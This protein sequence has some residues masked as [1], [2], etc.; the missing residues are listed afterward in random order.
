M[1]ENGQV[2]K[3]REKNRKTSRFKSLLPRRKNERRRVE[4]LGGLA[5]S[6][7]SLLV[8][9]VFLASS[10]D[11][12]LIRSNQY[13]SV[14]AAVLV[15]LTNGDRTQNSLHTLTMNPT[16]VAAAQA[17]ANDMATKGY[18]A[19]VGPDGKDSWYWFKEIGYGFSYAGE[20]LAVDFSDSGDVE[21]AWMNS[22]L[23]RQNLLDPHFTE[24]GI[25]TAQGK[26]QGHA[27]T[28]VVQMFGTSAEAA[29]IKEPVR[30]ITSPQNATEPAIATTQ[31]TPVNVLGETSG[32]TTSKPLPDMRGSEAASIDAHYAPLWAHIATA[33]RSMLL[34][35][36]WI[37]AF[38]V[39]LALGIATGFELHVHHRRK[40][41]T[42]GL[43]LSFIIVMFIA[44]NTFIFTPPI[45]TP[46]A[47]MTA[48]ASF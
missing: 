47:S 11:R 10:I 27:T 45:L 18:F 39:I 29:A 9:S 20:N 25:A 40:A 26:Y 12:Y 31:P 38:L 16:L 1:C 21:R 22:P 15:D 36:Y 23:H 28:F 14:L 42:A 7:F 46:Q 8:V 3:N 32:K 43:L 48:S 2:R 17:K 34:Y 5:V 4:L 24:I 37:L 13:A 19:H 44:A 35:A 6:I 30:E 41:L 33:P